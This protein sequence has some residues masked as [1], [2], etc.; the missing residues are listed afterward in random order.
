[1][2]PTRPLP[3][4]WPEGQPWPPPETEAY[5]ARPAW[6]PNGQSWPPPV[7]AKTAAADYAFP[8]RVA[9]LFAIAINLMGAG[10][11][12][13]ARG[14][15]DALMW[16][17]A[18]PLAAAA[19]VAIT[20]GMFVLAMRRVGS[21]L[22]EIMAAAHRV[23]NGDFSVR[24]EEEGLPWLRSL[25]AAFNTMTSRLERQQRERRAFMADIAHEL[26]TPVAVVQ[27]R[28]E[29]MLD[30]IYPRDEQHVRQVLEDTRMLAR[31]VEDLRTSSDLETGTLSL[32]I[33]AI[34]LGA[35]VEE[36]ARTLD[37]DAAHRRVRLD[38]RAVS[39]I[40]PIDADPHRIRQVL[41]NLLSNAIRHSPDEGVVTIRCDRESGAVVVRVADQGPGIPAENLRHIFERYHKG[42]DSAGSGLG[43][44][45]AMSLVQA[46]G[47]AIAAENLPEGGTVI[48]MVLPIPKQDATS[49]PI[50]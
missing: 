12:G 6:W 34:D 45:I 50:N 14:T 26:R 22:S 32:K 11:F 47:G 9:V 16:P 31:L 13:L 19:L 24:L 35:L 10:A 25:A 17:Y 5:R 28:V 15:I 42:E 48:T 1:M 23:G 4:W 40:P 27:G 20:A 44:T 49:R 30:G 39:D 18:W 29:G 21:P 8:L 3:D 41:I 2:P 38:T 46:H 37:A 7:A 33:E 43:L 36:T